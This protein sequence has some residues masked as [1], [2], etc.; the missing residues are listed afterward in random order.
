MPR[1]FKRQDTVADGLRPDP[2]VA[3]I[4]NRSKHSVGHPADAELK[5]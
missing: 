3:R 2:K 5:G 1:S 4:G